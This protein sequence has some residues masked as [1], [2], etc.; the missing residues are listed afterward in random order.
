MRFLNKVSLA[1]YALL[2]ILFLLSCSASTPPTPT[3]IPDL[4]DPEVFNAIMTVVGVSD[5]SQYTREDHPFSLLPGSEVW[6]FSLVARQNVLYTVR[7]RGVR[8]NPVGRK[9]VLNLRGLESGKYAVEITASSASAAL[10]LGGAYTS[11]S[12]RDSTVFFWIKVTEANPERVFYI[13]PTGNDA[14]TGGQQSPWRTPHLSVAKLV[15]GDTLIFLD[16]EY[17]LSEFDEIIIPPSGTEDAWITLTGA[18]GFKPSIKG[19]N[20]LYSAIILS[21]VSYIK[22]S[23]LEFTSVT[24]EYFRD[25]INGVDGPINHIVL[26]DLDIH[27]IDE[28]GINFRDV[29]HL[30]VLDCRIFYCGFGAIGGPPAENDGWRHILIR[31]CDLSYS[32]HYYQG[33]EDNPLNP[34]DRPD[35]LGLEASDG[36]IEIVRVTVRHNRGDGLDSK[37]ANTFI[38]HC[39]VSN[40]YA[41]GIKLWGAGSK[42]ENTLIC[43][44]GDGSLESGWCPFVISY[45]GAPNATFK[46]TNVT[47]ADTPDRPSYSAH[48]QYDSTVPIRVTLKNCIFANAYGTV[49]A[50]VNVDLIVDH[51]HFYRPNDAVQLEAHGRTY[52][53]DQIAAGQ[54]GVGNSV[55]NPLFLNPVWASDAFDYHLEGTSPAVDTGTST[56]APSDDLD[57]TA[58]PLG[59]GVDKGCY[60]RAGSTPIGEG[61][62]VDHLATNISSIPR[63]WIEAVKTHSILHYARRSHG[64]QLNVGAEW[65]QSQNALYAYSENWCALPEPSNAL[66]VW[67]GQTPEIGDYI[68][69]WDYWE[70]PEGLAVTRAILTANPSIKYSMWSWCTELDE[71][72]AEQ[73]DAYLAAISALEAEFPQVRFIYMTGNAQ[74]TGAEGWNRH[75]RNEQIR[76]YCRANNKV[77]YDFADLD[78]WYQGVQATTSYAGHTYPIQHNAY[79]SP[80]YEGTHV[81]RQ[82]CSVKASALWWLMA[83]LEGWGGI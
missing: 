38:H 51:C 59:A 22:I 37:A 3:P 54:A 55:G 40:N 27:H 6:E 9:Y 13:S 63:N 56:G 57:G 1:L 32:G 61:I 25:A 11:A 10:K 28:F 50:N 35:G 14:G 12:S 5:P 53:A 58:R 47:I 2:A 26:E 69:P 60:E 74:A 81:N 44:T 73:V 45:W 30:Q 52:T 70:A 42:V 43:G 72:S 68:F 16:G 21:D 71:W 76:A 78:C 29:E 17:V 15:P 49:Y 82:S 33:V 7:F 36:P 19:E 64:S 41:D 66:R 77:L 4:T 8:V 75:L 80:E 34:Y 24:G 39:L 67:N 79:A 31:D 65:L 83:R 62:V 48:I 18:P 20:N 23:N 46:L